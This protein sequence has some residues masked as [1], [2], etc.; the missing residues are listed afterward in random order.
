METTIKTFLYFEFKEFMPF[1]VS[2]CGNICDIKLG[3][4][5]VWFISVSSESFS[6]QYSAPGVSS[7]SIWLCGS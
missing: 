2:S 1:V 4:A 7:F 5:E 3:N 6:L